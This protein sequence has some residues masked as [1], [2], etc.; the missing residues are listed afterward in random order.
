MVPRSSVISGRFKNDVEALKDQAILEMQMEEI[1]L[2]DEEI[3]VKVAQAAAARDVEVSRSEEAQ[4][5]D[6]RAEANEL[7]KQKRKTT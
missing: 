1:R 7:S 5:R 6:S 3:R 4:K 2:K